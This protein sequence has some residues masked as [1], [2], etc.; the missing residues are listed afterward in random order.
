[1]E[2][3]PPLKRQVAGSYPAGS[4]K[5]PS[6]PRSSTWATNFSWPK[7]GKLKL[8]RTAGVAGLPKAV[9]QPGVA[10]V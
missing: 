6:R 2:E 10:E 5:L 7:A 9:F 1:L 8:G 3:Q 4:T